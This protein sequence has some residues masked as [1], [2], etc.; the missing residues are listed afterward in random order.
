MARTAQLPVTSLPISPGASAPA[1]S[2]LL[3]VM[4]RVHPRDTRALVALKPIVGFA[5]LVGFFL[6]A[7]KRRSSAETIAEIDYV[8]LE[9]AFAIS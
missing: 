9:K 3:S 7:L 5:I 1:P 2:T 6:V 4:D 8:I